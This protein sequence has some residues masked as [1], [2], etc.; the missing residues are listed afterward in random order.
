M[1]ALSIKQPWAWL[2]CAGYKD[3]ENRNW[4]IGRSPRHGPYSSR[5]VDNFSI[6][7]PSRIYVH[8]GMKVDNEGAIW[9]W[10]CKELLGI[11][12][13][14]PQW[15]D[16]CNTWKRSAIIGEV[17]ITGC[18]EKSDSFWFVGPY[19]FTLANPLL[20]EKP[21]PCKGKLG[22]FDVEAPVA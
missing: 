20:Y 2:I 7:L 4:R 8:A 6:E 15:V 17:D 12:G 13:C 9:L 21:I 3:I 5:D 14:M 18:V 16:I 22:F 10:D 11:Q 1:K 19:G